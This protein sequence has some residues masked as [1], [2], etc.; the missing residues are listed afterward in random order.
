[1]LRK[2]DS[3]PAGDITIQ[4]PVMEPYFITKSLTG[5]YAV[6][7]RVVK[8]DKNTPYLNTVCYP[9]TFNHALKVVARELLKTGK[10]EYHTVKEYLKEWD[11]I[12]EKMHTITGVD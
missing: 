4:D 12:Q 1:M 6:Y 7:E 10:T 8:G 2:P 11:S 5:G 3:I 9:S